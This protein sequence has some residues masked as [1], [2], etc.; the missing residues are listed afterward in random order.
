MLWIDSSDL[1][2]SSYLLFDIVLHSVVVLKEH[3]IKVK[4]FPFV[5]FF[6]RFVVWR[7]SFTLV[8][9]FSQTKLVHLIHLRIRFKRVSQPQF[10]VLSH[11]VRSTI[12]RGLCILQNWRS[13][14]LLLSGEHLGM[15]RIWN[16][17]G[18]E[19]PKHLSLILL[20][21]YLVD[22]VPRFV[23]LLINLFLLLGHFVV[24]IQ[25]EISRGLHNS[26]RERSVTHLHSIG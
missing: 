10:L 14:W 5:K 9:R 15:T 12:L 11:T 4:I 26:Q 25:D 22:V 19:R 8:N 23:R 7:V 16:D 2:D 17:T 21:Y 1:P 24:D 6:D 20:R 13:S 3:V 18:L